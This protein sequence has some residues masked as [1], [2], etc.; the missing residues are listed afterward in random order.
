MV[1]SQWPSLSLRHVLVIDVGFTSEIQ[2]RKWR[3]QQ[4]WTQQ[5]N[6]NIDFLHSTW[7]NGSNFIRFHVWQVGEGRRLGIPA[8]YRFAKSL[9]HPVICR[10]SLF[11]WV[12]FFLKLINTRG[13]QCIS[14]LVLWLFKHHWM[15]SKS[16]EDR[17]F[18]RESFWKR[19]MTRSLLLFDVTAA[20]LM[21]SCLSDSTTLSHTVV[22]F[23]I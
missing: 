14:K 16:N 7:R 1:S 8:W 3:F 22:C 21:V 19:T 6:H 13:T 18:V 10:N 15:W 9:L 23:V 20:G 11:L 2:Y 5:F 4:D 17:I 12:W